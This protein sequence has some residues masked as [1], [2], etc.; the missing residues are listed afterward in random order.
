MAYHRNQRLHHEGI[1]PS[2][3]GSNLTRGKELK[4]PVKGDYNGEENLTLVVHSSNLR[5]Q[6]GRVRGN[7]YSELEE[8]MGGG[9]QARGLPAIDLVIPA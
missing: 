5:P 3:K 4:D 7:H 1:L 2:A 6:A 9:R 8:V